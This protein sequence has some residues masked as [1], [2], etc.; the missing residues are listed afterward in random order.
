M[1]VG[2]IA[3]TALILAGIIHFRYVSSK[4]KQLKNR[5]RYDNTH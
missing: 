4:E 5:D 3:I 1:L 2:S